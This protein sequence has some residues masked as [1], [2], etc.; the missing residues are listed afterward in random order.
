MKNISYDL[1]EKFREAGHGEAAETEILRTSGEAA[2]L[3]ALSPNRENLFEWYPWKKDTEVLLFGADC[4]AVCGM[5]SEAVGALSVKDERPENLE[6]IRFRYPEKL[7]E[8][9]G[10][11][12]LI[13]KTIANQYDA[14]VIADITKEMIAEN[15]PESEAA[16]KLMSGAGLACA[17]ALS[18]FLKR[19]ASC[20]REGGCLMFAVDNASALKFMTGADWDKDRIYTEHEALA[21]ILEE[22][23]FAEQKWYYPLPESRLSKDIFSDGH[24]PADGDFRGVSDAYDAPRLQFCDEEAV[25]GKLC[26]CGAFAE[27]APSYLLVLSGYE[28]LCAEEKGGEAADFN[29]VREAEPFKTAEAVVQKGGGPEAVSGAEGASAAEAFSEPELTASGAR[30][31]RADQ[32]ARRANVPPH[33]PKQIYIRYNRTRIPQYQTKTEISEENGTRTV[34]KTALTKAANDHILSFEWK[35]K[36]LKKDKDIKLNV[37]EPKFGKTQGGNYRAEFEYLEGTT[38]A[39]LLAAEISNGRAPVAA[40]KDALELVL[41][42]GAHECHN[43][44]CLFENV[45]KCGGAY[46]YLDYEWVFENVLDRDYLRYRMLRYWYEAYREALYTYAGLSDFLA[47]FGIKEEELPEFEKMEQSFQQFVHG[48]GQQSFIEHYKQPSRR[49]AD[50]QD[51]DRKIAEFTEWNLRL[52]DEVEEHKETIAKDLE[53]MRLTQNHILNIEKANR[54][55]ERDIAN[56]LEELTYLRK[57]ESVLAKAGRGIGAGFAKLLPQS[58]RKRKM[59]HYAAHPFKSLGMY[60]SEEGRNLISGDFNIGAEYLEG[61]KLRLPDCLHYDSLTAAPEAVTSETA[62]EAS[63]Q[64]EAAANAAQKV[65]PRVSIVLPVYNQIAY[66]YACVRSILEHTDFAET[67]YEVILADDV[68]KDA[69][70]IIERYI[71]GLVISRNTENQGFLKNCNQAAKKVAG[72]YIFFLNNDTKVTDGWL[73]SLLELM[74]KDEQIGMAGSKLIYPDGRLQE[75][76]GIIWSD[77]SGWNYGRLDDPEKPQYNYVKDV[78][79]IS[80]AAIMIRRALWEEIGGFDERFAPAYCEDSDLA[81][82]VRKHGKRVVYQPKSVVIHFEGISNGTDVNGTGLKKYQLVNQEKFK[83]KWKTELKKQSK[84]TGDP[85]PFSARDRSQA[86]PCV[87]FVDHYVPT[88][89]KDA[90]S[91]TTFQ[92][93]KMLLKKGYNVKFLGD[94]FLHEEPYSTELLQMGVEILYG[95]QMQSGIWEWLKENQEFIDIAYLNRPHIAMKYIDFIRENTN[96]KCIYYGHDLHFLRLLREYELSGDIRKKRESDYWKS[97]E[98]TVMQKSD[99]SYYPSE[100]EIEAVHALDPKIRVKA[101]TAYVWEEF[102]KIT[103]APETEEQDYAKREGLL[104]VGGF[105]HPPNEDGVLWFAREIFPKIR[106]EKPEIKLYIAGSKASDE[107]KALGASPE[108]TGI[109]VLGF[110]SDERLSE[111]YRETK[112]TVVP[113]RYGAGVK[114]KVVEALYHGSVVV[115]TSVGAEG[116]PAAQDVLAVVNETDA[117]IYEHAEETA[118]KFADAVLKL[119]GDDAVCAAISRKTRQYVREYYSADAA[120]KAVAEDF[121][122]TKKT[123]EA[124]KKAASGKKRK[125]AVLAEE[126]ETGSI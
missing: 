112:L 87:L 94:N 100:R 85:N 54:I 14:V 12:S 121:A 68:S 26:R 105:A 96:I 58:S 39:K 63:A 53:V 119:Y 23:P 88:W 44:D 52:Q 16:A 48:D 38:L 8:N 20:L 79:Y 92:Y 46:Y 111:L 116:V 33:S 36:L 75:A 104:F 43:M 73:S 31:I 10:N 99:M 81:F 83:E 27:F 60:F 102:A 66:T 49:R 67:P 89:D 1:I 64:A 15:L 106:A 101:I 18:A 28:G 76:G 25:Y 70:A 124:P 13:K 114:G 32:H 126:D 86:K 113:L 90:G 21:K 115:T 120:W 11:I 71:E 17:E 61:G 56:M 59:L 35:Y 72:D 118:Q 41:G 24:L 5:L 91:K 95:E 74:D 57:H 108:E 125:N 103:E 51:M 122:V 97:I 55:H 84:N 19:A 22:L 9:G 42:I 109:E 47:A 65:R 78:D 69:T 37:Q 117:D 82:E 98:F 7:K 3:Y 34:V 4:G 80:G 30:L 77:A 107:I 123:E 93:I 29:N 40:I 110:V 2:Y 50:I 45:M 62:A 6:V